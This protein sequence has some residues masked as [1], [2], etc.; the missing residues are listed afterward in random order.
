M[1][2]ILIPGLWLDGQSWAQVTPQLEAAGH[3]VV[4]LTL[5]GMSRGDD[6]SFIGIQDHVN[7]VIAAIDGHDPNTPVVLI[8][9]SGGGVVAHAAVDARPARV[10]RVV[11]VASEPVSDGGCINDELPVLNGEV[12]LPAWSFFDED[13]LIDM[14]H[15]LLADFRERAIPSPAKVCSD[16]VHLGDARRY[17]VPITM[18]T[19][20]YP[21]SLLKAWM[22]QGLP[23]ALELTKIK[24]IDWI[25]LPT[26]HWP[27]F[28][29]PNELAEAI[30]ASL[31]S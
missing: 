15:D 4:C 9:H 14:N 10:N 11:Y 8:G 28:T 27:Q 26:G 3:D 29:R 30:L 17:D 25:D 7:A 23:G 1:H 19:C 2:L 5:P 16:P 21:S 13:M 22:A 6:R 31:A 24:H 20:E 12:P 18:I